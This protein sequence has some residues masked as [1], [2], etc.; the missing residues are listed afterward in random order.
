MNKQ[1]IVARLIK[2]IIIV[3]LS[4]GWIV[5]IWMGIHKLLL[6]VYHIH[7]PN[8]H[9]E[10]DSG[11]HVQLLT[12]AFWV[13]IAANKLWPIKPRKTGDEGKRVGNQN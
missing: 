10:I 12:I 5:P 3:I 2:N 6:W 11:F 4:V 13:F 9:K 1:V 7:Q 8:Y